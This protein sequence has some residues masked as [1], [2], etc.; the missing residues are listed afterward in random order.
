MINMAR[1]GRIVVLQVSGKELN[2]AGKNLAFLQAI[3]YGNATGKVVRDSDIHANFG[4]VY[5]STE[6]RDTLAELVRDGSIQRHEG[7]EVTYT[8]TGEGIGRERALQERLGEIA[9]SILNR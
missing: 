5:G 8:I 9:R 1:T 3:A 4:V 6:I 2:L 7:K